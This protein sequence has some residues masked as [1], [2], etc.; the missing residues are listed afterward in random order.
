MAE[1]EASDRAAMTKDQQVEK[2]GQLIQQY[3]ADQN[4][5]IVVKDIAHL[6]EEME[7]W[8]DA[9][10]FYDWAFQISNGDAALKLK[11]GQIGDRVANES[12]KELEA[13]LEAD[14]NN[15]ELRAQVMSSKQLRAK[16]SVAEAE[17]RVEH[18]PTDPQLRYD[19]GSALYNAGEY[20]EAIPHLQQATRNPHIRTRVLLTLAR[21]FDAKSMYDLALK[22]LADA[23]ADLHVMDTTKKEVLYEKGLIHE[24]M[25]VKEEA[26]E[27][28]KQIYETD[29]G[30]R[31]VA[32]RVE[33]SYS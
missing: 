25:G 20:S 17:N 9:H 24:K 13:Q 16:E 5:L 7:N 27:C 15:D 4:N 22:Q 32:T 10:A 2:L 19:L 18:N 8:K 11:A 12:M 14:P 1:L 33:S 29:Y 3:Q 31:D 23:L 6:Y 26:L 30:Y 28:F 21:A